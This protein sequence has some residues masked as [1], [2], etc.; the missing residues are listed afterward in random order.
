MEL[1]IILSVIII[2]SIFQSVMGIG[3]LLFGTPTF[4]ILG[5][6][7]IET[8]NLVL[9]PSITISFL[10]IIYFNDKHDIKISHF[11]K[12]FLMFCIPSLVLGLFIMSKNYELINFNFT[13][14]IILFFV[15]LLRFSKKINL[16]LKS[17]INK[18]SRT[19]FLFIGIMHGFTN[20]GGSFLS[21]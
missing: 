21:L 15:A 17:K 5:Y 13:L 6:S 10:Q 1:L 8:L 3:L 11:K 2:F 4:L 18:Y 7:F 19:S 9:L 14:G 16:I 12:E 20:L